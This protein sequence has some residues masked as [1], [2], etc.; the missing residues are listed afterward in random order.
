MFL[1]KIKKIIYFTIL[2][3]KILEIDITENGAQNTKIKM[4]IL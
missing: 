4:A 1:I 3:S 2:I